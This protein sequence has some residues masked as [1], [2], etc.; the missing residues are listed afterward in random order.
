MA[1]IRFL[2]ICNFGFSVAFSSSMIP[3]VLIIFV[4]KGQDL[5]I[6]VDVRNVRRFLLRLR[7]HPSFGNMEAVGAGLLRMEALR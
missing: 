2:V 6:Q 7:H 3:I 1:E 5:C 4:R